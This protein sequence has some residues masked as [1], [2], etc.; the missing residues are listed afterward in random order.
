MR[1]VFPIIPASSGPFWFLG[2]L[3]VLLVGLL[4]LFACLAYS[5][6]HVK[7]EVSAEGLRITGDIYGRM[8]PAQALAADQTRA[9]DLTR[10]REHRPSWRTNGAG[11]PGY[12]AGWFRL[13]NGE[14][15]LVFVTNPKSVVFIPTQQGYSVLLS[16]AQPD[17]FVQAIR[18]I[19]ARFRN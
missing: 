16:V 2:G 11:L 1:Q 10:D 5:S 8:I 13:V 19:A 3:S 15:G 12:K 14:K 4:I 7:F 9:V 17:E 18:Q 6:R